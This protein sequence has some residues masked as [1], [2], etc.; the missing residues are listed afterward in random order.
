MKKEKVLVVEARNG[1]ANIL[2][3]LGYECFKPGELLKFKKSLYKIK[4]K[5][6]WIGIEKIS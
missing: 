4:E 5:G 1:E 2:G 6:I 3:M